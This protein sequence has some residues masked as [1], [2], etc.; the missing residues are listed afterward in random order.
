MHE[1]A[2]AMYVTG[3]LEAKP[4]CILMYYAGLAG[5]VGVDDLG[6]QPGVSTG[7]YS[8]HLKL[9]LGLNDT[10]MLTIIPHYHYPL[11]GGL[12]YFVAQGYAL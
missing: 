3:A 2:V 7:N 4:L 11:L 9:V 6:H 5:A 10:D 8:K 1:L 12:T